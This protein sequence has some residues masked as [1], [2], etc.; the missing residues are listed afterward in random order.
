MEQLLYQ[1]ILTSDRKVSAAS[2][3]SVVVQLLGLFF[4]V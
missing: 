4:G 3:E 2:G 1:G